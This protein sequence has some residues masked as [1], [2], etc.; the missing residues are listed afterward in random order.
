M[1]NLSPDDDAVAAKFQAAHYLGRSVIG[2]I[3]QTSVV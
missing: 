2:A 1:H 3:A